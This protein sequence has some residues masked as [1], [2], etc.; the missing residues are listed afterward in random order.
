MVSS[1]DVVASAV[2]AAKVVAIVVVYCGDGANATLLQ[3]L[4][5]LVVLLL[6]LQLM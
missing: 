2:D 3:L 6:L 1:S 5:Q 4:L